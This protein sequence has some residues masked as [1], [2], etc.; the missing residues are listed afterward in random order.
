MKNRLVEWSAKWSAGHLAST[1]TCLSNIGLFG[2][3][4]WFRLLSASLLIPLLSTPGGCLCYFK[5]VKYLFQAQKAEIC[6]SR[7]SEVQNTLH[8]YLNLYHWLVLDDLRFLSELNEQIT[9]QV[10]KN[11]EDGRDSRE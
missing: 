9:P 3:G 7:F 10:A 8:R 1:E 5:T 4:L 11:F 6:M 2:N